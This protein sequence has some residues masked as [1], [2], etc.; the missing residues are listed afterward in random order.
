MQSCL[1]WKSR[2]KNCPLSLFLS[3]SFCQF[4]DVILYTSRGMMQTNQFKVHGQLPLHGM[5]V[6]AVSLCRSALSSC[7]QFA[8]AKPNLPGSPPQPTPPVSPL[9]PC[10]GPRCPRSRCPL[11]FF[12]RRP[13]LLLQIRESEDEWGVP[14][15]F[16]LVGQQQSV[17]VAAR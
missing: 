9:I 5:T 2:L 11:M 16:T 10:F 8:S 17:V 6:S 15:A 14:H 1:K 3:L 7:H 12:P 4:N 13:V